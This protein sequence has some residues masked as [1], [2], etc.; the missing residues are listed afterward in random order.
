MLE[1][2]HLVKRFFGT[3]VV[4]GVSFEVRAHFQ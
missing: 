4:N 2:R 3:E 1:A